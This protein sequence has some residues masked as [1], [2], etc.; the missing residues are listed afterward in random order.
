MCKRPLSRIS[1]LGEYHAITKGDSGKYGQVHGP[2]HHCGPNP[3]RINGYFQHCGIVQHPY[4]KVFKSDAGQPQE[5]SLLHKRLEGTLNQIR[6]QCPRRITD[7]E[8]QQHLKDNLFHR[9]HKH[10]MDSIRYLY[11]NPR[12]IYSQP[13]IAAHKAETEN[14]EVCNKV[15]S[16]SAMT[17][18]PVEGMTAGQGNSP[19]S[20]P[21][22]PRQRGCGREW[23]DRNTSGHPNSCNG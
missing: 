4:A 23:M 21:N 19:T 18:E 2:Y 13:V 10:I 8:V 1:G 3:S 15:R 11:S 6:L 9:V 17:T 5:G 14:E 12:T 22:S 16:R 20:A 7:Q